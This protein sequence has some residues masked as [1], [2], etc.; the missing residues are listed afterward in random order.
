M[1]A[2]SI[3]AGDFYELFMSASTPV[4]LNHDNI[5]LG[6]HWLKIIKEADAGG[7]Y[8][9]N[10]DDAV[11]GGQDGFNSGSSHVENQKQNQEQHQKRNQERNKD[12]RANTDDTKLR[13]FLSKAVISAWSAGA[14]DYIKYL[15]RE[16]GG[17]YIE[18]EYLAPRPIRKHYDASVGFAK[19]AKWLLASAAGEIL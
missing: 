17:K 10:I 9:D 19:Q 15:S 6:P 12:Q 14:N 8:F 5:G 2:D 7:F 4:V 16:D 3:S 11:G 13:D 18:A 1:D